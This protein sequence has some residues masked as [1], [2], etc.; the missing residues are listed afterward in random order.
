MWEGGGERS[1]GESVECSLGGSGLDLGVG[2][3]R[4]HHDNQAT[5]V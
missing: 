3:K 4:E 1:R 5:A 2:G